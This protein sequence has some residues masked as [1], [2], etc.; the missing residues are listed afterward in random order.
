PQEQDTCGT[1]SGP[2]RTATCAVT[3]QNHYRCKNCNVEGHAA[4]SRDCPT[5][6][7]K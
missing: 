2:H 4:W 1:C 7:N 3:D 5:F 6:V